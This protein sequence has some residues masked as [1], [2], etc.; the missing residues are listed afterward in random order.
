[1]KYTRRY[2]VYFNDVYFR[3]SV[4]HIINIVLTFLGV[5][6]INTRQSFKKVDLE[7]KNTKLIEY[8]MEMNYE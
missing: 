4:K 8:I 6:N 5:V 3:V 7:V 1:M 2:D